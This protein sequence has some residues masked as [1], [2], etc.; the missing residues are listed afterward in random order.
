MSPQPRKPVPTTA[1]RR[2]AT[3]GIR[4]PRVAGRPDTG[5]PDTGRPDA[6]GETAETEVR[7]DVTRADSR[8]A[9]FEPETEALTAPEVEDE[10]ETAAVPAAEEA[11]GAGE[12]GAGERPDGARARRARRARRERA[13]AFGE[14]A[15]TT[16]ETAGEAAGEDRPRRGLTDLLRVPAPPRTKRGTTIL[17]GVTVVALALAVLAG[18]SWWSMKSTPAAQNTALVDVAATT[19]VSQQLGDAVKTVYSYDYT[20]LDQNEAAAREVI[21]PEFGQQ[22]DQLFGEVRKLAPE[23][24][25]VVT[26]TI[27]QAAVESIAGDRA[28]LVVFLDQQATRAASDQAGQQV[29]A[30]GRLTVT[31]QLVDGTWKIADVA[32]A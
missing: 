17:A 30:A 15:E 4:R 18:V 8:H 26:A 11:D 14:P 25:A 10:A 31:G 2:R 5:R 20:R 32:V 29:A 24:Q 28:V 22:F 12:T 23:Q 21:T 9:L 13:E 3:T 7:P 16:A 19:Q 27:S 6:P 1:S